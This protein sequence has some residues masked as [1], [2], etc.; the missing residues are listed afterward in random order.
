VV[1][2]GYAIDN[3]IF[4]PVFDMRTLGLQSRNP[5]NDADGEVEAAHLIAYREL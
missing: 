3:L 5:V 4:E 1:R 2:V